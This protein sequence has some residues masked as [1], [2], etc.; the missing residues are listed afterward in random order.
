MYIYYFMNW[1]AQ[2]PHSCSFTCCCTAE[3]SIRS[4]PTC[5]QSGL[6]YQ[7]GM[8]VSTCSAVTTFADKAVYLPLSDG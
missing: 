4:P 8:D 2:Q 3:R 5:L 7:L 6:S 1:A